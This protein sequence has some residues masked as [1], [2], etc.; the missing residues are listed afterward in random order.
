MTVKSGFIRKLVALYLVAVLP[1]TAFIGVGFYRS[2]RDSR[3][4]AVEE[5]Y[6]RAK[7]AAESLDRFVAEVAERNRSVGTSINAGKMSV[8]Q[9]NELL[10]RLKEGLPITDVY[11]VND[12]G[13]VTASSAPALAGLNIAELNDFQK[14]KK[15]GLGWTVTGFKR[16]G[17]GDYGFSVLAAVRSGGRL[18]A[19]CGANIDGR[20]LGSI[21]PKEIGGKTV[22]F[23]DPNGT[24]VFNSAA[25]SMGIAARQWAS[26]EPISVSLG[27]Q[28][29]KT[30][31]TLLP[32]GKESLTG[33]FIPSSFGWSVGYL[34][35]SDEALVE[36]DG[37]MALLFLMTLAVIALS[38]GLSLY[39]IKRLS[40]PVAELASES[41]IKGNS[42]RRIHL[43]SGDELERIA[44][45]FNK[46]LDDIDAQAE[47]VNRLAEVSRIFNSDLALEAICA[48]ASSYLKNL[49]GVERVIVSVDSE[50]TSSIVYKDGLDESVAEHAASTA[51]TLHDATAS[52]KEAFG[53]FNFG[54]EGVPP[55]LR[56]AGAKALFSLPLI[57]KGTPIGRIDTLIGDSP[58][59]LGRGE[60]SLTV[61]FSQLMALAL[62][63]RSA[64]E[65]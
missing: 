38:A 44:D 54:E 6:N 33:A 14:L 21:L 41:E 65:L 28:A 42:E 46:V 5:Q 23:A 13:K 32:G 64:L 63:R 29:Y 55:A 15:E 45:N 35:P 51:R 3:E 57:D 62:A 26:Y 31:S 39:Q 10:G 40:D 52:D 17:D 1:L 11:Y 36:T 4:R 7:L 8:K 47:A 61:C 34:T 49:L 18:V 25:P 48:K 53:Y 56:E 60:R 12:S 50:E 27:N 16:H 59:K 20:D 30:E 22:I 58:I 24:V 19:V 9:A 37:K 2:F 43:R